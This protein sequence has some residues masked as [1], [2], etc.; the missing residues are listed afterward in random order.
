MLTLAEAQLFARAGFEVRHADWPKADFM[1]FVQG[2]AQP[3]DHYTIALYTPTVAEAV[4]DQ[5]ELA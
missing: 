3:A 5:W 4:S 2:A 1:R